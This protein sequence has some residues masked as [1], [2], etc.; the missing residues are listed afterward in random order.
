LQNIEKN[1]IKVNQISLSKNDTVCAVIVTY[2]RRSLLLACL[3]ALKK[4][5]KSI[6]GIYI[7]DNASTDDTSKKLLE[8]NYIPKLPP[9]NLTKPWEI[10]FS[11]TNSLIKTINS[12]SQIK[13][14]YI[15][16]HKNT[17]ATGGFYEGVK[18]GYNQG[19]DW[20]WLMDDDAEPKEDALEKLS[21]YF[22][23][24]N[25]S[26]LASIVKNA[27]GISFNHRG[28]VDF[29]RIFP[30]IQKPL[31]AEFYKNNNSVEIDMASFVG[32]LV[33]RKAV[34]KINYPKKEFFIH[35]DDVEY[36]IRLRKTGKILLITD[37]IIIHKDSGEQKGIYK[38]FLGKG[39]LRT[40]YD[41][42]WIKYYG[43][44]NLIWLGKKYSINKFNFYCIGFWT[45]LHSIVGIIVYD[46]YK[47]KRI[48]LITNAYLDGL[49][50]V[51]DNKKPKKILYEEIRGK[52]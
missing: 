50:N 22:K 45:Y 15:K 32:I 36:C 34:R 12:Q 13:I 41:K 28:I 18:R 30:L 35:H 52:K 24:K 39:S 2:N 37:S 4:Q 1:N 49:N 44:R 5:S 27:S 43:R 29:K 16:M 21:N 23:E 14:Y 9:A 46:D 10:S 38:Y 40:P 42:L 48:K 17:G 31:R 20:L 7:I 6:N 19:Y 8:N 11:I 51:F 47:L 26:A 25:V 33:S 3:K